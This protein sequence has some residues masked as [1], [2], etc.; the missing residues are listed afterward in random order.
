[1]ALLFLAGVMVPV[2]TNVDVTSDIR[3]ITAGE[4]GLDEVVIDAA[5]EDGPDEVDVDAAPAA[6][7]I[8]G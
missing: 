6:I 8:G 3:S 4:E 1:M 7:F 2:E 5:G